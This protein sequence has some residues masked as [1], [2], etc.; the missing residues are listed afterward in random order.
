MSCL[1]EALYRHVVHREQA[2]S[3]A[4]RR[5]APRRSPVKAARRQVLLLASELLSFSP[6]RRQLR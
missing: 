4:P 6:V 3:H 1:R 5:A 2:L